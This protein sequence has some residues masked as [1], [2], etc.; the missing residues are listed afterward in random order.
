MARQYN[1]LLQ[2]TDPTQNILFFSLLNLGL[3]KMDSH[4]VFGTSAID[5]Y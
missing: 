3:L 2:L 5:H 4:I 1:K